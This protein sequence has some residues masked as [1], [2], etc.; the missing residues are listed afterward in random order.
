MQLRPL[1][2]TGLSV[3]RL[4][5]GT[6][7][8]GGSV[9]PDDAGAQL[10]AFL[11]AGGTLV[12]T[13]AGYEDGGSEEVL[14]E[15][16]AGG[17][18]DEIV[19]ATKAGI[20]RR[21]GTRVVDT[22]RRTLLADL[23]GSLRRLGVDH[24]DLWQIHAWGSAP[25]AETLETLDVALASGRTRYVGISNFS[26]WQTGTA[27]A[28]QA[29]W[30]GRARLSSTQMEWNLLRRGVEA[31]VVPAA[32]HHGLG[33]LAWSPL[34]GGVLTGKYSGGVP[35][36]SRGADDHWRDRIATYLDDRQ[37]AVVDALVTAADGLGVSPLAVALAWL[38]DRPGLTAAIV[39][40][41]TPGQLAGILD[42]ESLELPAAIRDA[43]DDVSS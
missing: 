36:D 30:P 20:S 32:A 10:H 7:G 22:S 18:R 34:A 35:R 43:L 25:L 28:W 29:A 4:G 16:V 1:G 24:V 40:A 17:L 19:L 26:G 37:A 13:A 41:R 8:W 39:G 6:M 11:D 33:V 27:A 15:L 21:S 2:R 9:S 23:D 3:S 5:L 31:E 14:G 42:S 38:R 12:D